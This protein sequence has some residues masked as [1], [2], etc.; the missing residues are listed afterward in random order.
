MKNIIYF[1]F[2][3]VLISSC[4][5][6]FNNSETLYKDG[7]TFTSNDKPITGIVY[8]NYPNDT[9]KFEIEY[10]KGKLNGFYKEYYD[11]G[12]L[13]KMGSFINGERNGQYQGYLND[14]TLFVEGLYLNNLKDSVWIINNV[15]GLIVEK[16]NY[17]GNQGT[18]I[19]YKQRD[20]LIGTNYNISG[21]IYFDD[22]TEGRQIGWTKKD[23]VMIHYQFDS[24]ISKR[25]GKIFEN[26]FVYDQYGG[27]NF[28]ENLKKY[29]FN[30]EEFFTDSV[31]S[32]GI[33]SLAVG[34]GPFRGKFPYG[35]FDKKEKLFKYFLQNGE[36]FFS[37]KYVFHNIVSE[38]DIIEIPNKDLYD[39][40]SWDG[41]TETEK[42]LRE[43][44][45]KA[46][47]YWSLMNELIEL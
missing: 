18:F 27:G 32:V 10:L 45:E 21:D 30:E 2:L 19:D 5:N 7:L 36:L 6:R 8:E 31:S 46:E 14:G 25:W 38:E 15:D 9:L 40:W 34:V 11:N 12:Q 33:Y 3:F 29:N 39:Q 22:G 41:S 17:S 4:N 16:L 20:T 1:S 28:F 26:H 37:S 13:K 44:Y 43:M 42:Q 23:P 35:V 47:E 24:I